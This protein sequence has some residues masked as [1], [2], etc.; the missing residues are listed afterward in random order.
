L[1]QTKVVDKI[2]AHVQFPPPHKIVLFRRQYG[3]G[4]AEQDRLQMAVYHGAG[5]M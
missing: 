3:K 5:A 4:M 1:F 2:K